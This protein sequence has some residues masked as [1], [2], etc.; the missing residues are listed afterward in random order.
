MDGTPEAETYK[1]WSWWVQ[2]FLLAKELHALPMAGGLFD[3]DWLH[4]EIFS[5]IAG[6]WASEDLAEVKKSGQKIHKR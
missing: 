4:I 6:V 3:Q 5:V 2:M 1:K